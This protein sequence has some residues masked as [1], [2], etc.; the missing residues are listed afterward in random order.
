MPPVSR[1]A[2]KLLLLLSGDSKN[3]KVCST[4]TLICFGPKWILDD[5]LR[6]RTS[7][8]SASLVQLEF[9]GYFHEKGQNVAILTLIS[10][11]HYHPLL[12]R[13]VAV[14]EVDITISIAQ[15]YG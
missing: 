2:S 9:L 8:V 3:T 14:Y 6:L 12:K 13:G 10:S 1:P 4:F 15:K 7:F 5:K 11:C